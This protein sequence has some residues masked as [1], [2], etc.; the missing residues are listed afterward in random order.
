MYVINISHCKSIGNHWIT[1][2]KNG[3]YVTCFDSFRVE[4]I[5]KENK[6]IRNKNIA[7]NIY[8]IQ[9][10]DSI[11]VDTLVLDLLILC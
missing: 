6:L 7:T 5:P 2:Y 1:L 9:S 4:Y 10:Y 3:N 11:M 8:K